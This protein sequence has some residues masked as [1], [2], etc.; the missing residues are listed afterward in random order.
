LGF[1]PLHRVPDGIDEIVRALEAG[2][3]GDPFDARFSNT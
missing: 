2:S 3:F 1:E